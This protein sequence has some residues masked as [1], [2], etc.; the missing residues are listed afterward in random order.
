[1][2]PPVA[3]DRRP[4]ARLRLPLSGVVVPGPGSLSVGIMPARGLEAPFT[5]DGAG[6]TAP[7]AGTTETVTTPRQPQWR[8][9]CG[10]S[11]LR[12]LALV[13]ICKIT[14]NLAQAPRE[15]ASNSS[16]S[17]VLAVRSPTAPASQ[18]GGRAHGRLPCAVRAPAGAPNPGG[19]A[20]DRHW[21]RA[22]ASG[23]AGAHWQAAH[24]LSHQP[25]PRT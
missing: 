4:T 17:L 7:R 19:S 24:G 15:Q 6:G 10:R 5:T 1:M 20:M 22:A 13:L 9:H 16:P 23:S 11:G 21:Q 12:W 25:G 8:W 14:I 2:L 18:H 3:I